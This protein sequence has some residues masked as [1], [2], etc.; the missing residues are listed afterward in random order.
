MWEVEYSL[1]FSLF[2]PFLR[3]VIIHGLG[4]D[5]YL[6]SGTQPTDI[7][8]AETAVRVIYYGDRGFGYDVGRIHIV[9]KQSV[10]ENTPHQ[11]QQHGI[12]GA[13]SAEFA[14]NNECYL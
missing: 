4:I 8:P 5:F 12:A 11:H 1:Y 14:C 13:D 3:F 10:H 6:W 7:L 9:V 2:H